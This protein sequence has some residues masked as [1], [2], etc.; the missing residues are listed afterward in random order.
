MKIR[1]PQSL[2]FALS[3]S[4]P[5]LGSLS[6]AVDI[7]GTH[8]YDGE[9]YEYTDKEQ[10]CIGYTEAANMTFENK[11]TFDMSTVD[12]ELIIGG[13]TCAANVDVK[14]GS[15]FNGSSRSVWMYTG[16]IV[17]DGESH[18][19]FCSN[20]T[21]GQNYRV[22][23]GTASGCV[24]TIKI[25]NGSTFTS[26]AS[27]FVAGYNYNSKVTIEVDGGSFVQTAQTK[28]ATSYHIGS[29]GVWEYK[30][31]RDLPEKWHNNDDRL[32]GWYDRDSKREDGSSVT[33]DTITYICDTGTNKVGLKY[34]SNDGVTAN[35]SAINKGKIDFQSTLTYVGGF[36]DKQAGH[37][38]K[39]ANFTIGDE[40]SMSFKR[41]E[42]YAATNIQNS[43]IFTATDVTLNDGATLTYTSLSDAANFTA[44][45]LT[46]EEGAEL[47]LVFGDEVETVSAA[48]LLSEALA[49]TDTNTIALSADLTLASGSELTI[50]GGVVDLSGKALTISDGVII[51]AI[52]LF[53]AEEEGLETLFANV[54]KL[55]MEDGVSVNV[56]GVTSRLFYNEGFVVVGAVP[57]PTTATLSLLALAGLAARRRRR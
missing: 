22:L 17:A 53:G 56:N 54:G 40:S 6:R 26:S 16:E 55:N 21:P 47:A 12:T 49:A 9:R 25:K 48:D 36:Q 42:I 3:L 31:N 29:S 2:L 1:L 52:G 39:S 46:V 51:N 13:K 57:E 28:N 18:I 11:A 24:S 10:V 37:T 38:N 23:L 15:T 7:T 14:N 35:I 5:M 32:D 34:N 45:S 27:Q 33:S 43:G 50:N 30:Y 4:V 41:M 8:T 19:N 20:E 44:D